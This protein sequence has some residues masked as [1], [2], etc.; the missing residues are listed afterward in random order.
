MKNLEEKEKKLRFALSKLKTMKLSFDE[1]NKNVLNIEN[2]KNQLKI[3]K[4]E[5]QQNYT[6]LNNEHQ[7][8][9]SKLEK[10][11]LTYSKNPYRRSW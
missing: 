6:N 8:L 7:N 2:Q 1:M 11:N 5:L 10:I 9:K 3:E 4:E